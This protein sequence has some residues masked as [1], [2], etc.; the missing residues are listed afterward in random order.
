[1]TVVV[2][3][4][5]I[6][7]ASVAYHLACRDAPVTLI[8]RGPS[9][10]AG[11]TAGSFAWIGG[12]A[13]GEWPGGAGAESRPVPP[14]PADAGPRGPR[15]AGAVSC[16]PDRR[17]PAT[18][19]SALKWRISLS[20]A[21][22]T[23]IGALFVPVPA[24]S[25]G[26]ELSTKDVDPGWLAGVSGAAPDPER[27]LSQVDGLYLW[28]DVPAGQTGLDVSVPTVRDQVR[29][30]AESVTF[31]QTDDGGSPLPGGLVLTGTVLD[32]S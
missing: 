16:P 31:Q 14:A 12:T 30:S 23:D 8:G 28:L 26:P 10:A 20:E 6:L 4:A 9:P 27:P 11:A 22:D 2:V 15:G 3:G 21:A 1:M 7:G 17:T 24:D 5:G 25:G 32:A 13:G 18:E 19:G 29:E